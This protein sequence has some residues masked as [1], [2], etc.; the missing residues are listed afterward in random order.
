MDL[1][2]TILETL[3][4][5]LVCFQ[6]TAAVSVQVDDARTRRVIDCA[7]GSVVGDIVA[8]L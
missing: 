5:D 4:H 6:A 3:I 1:K 7:G 2:R 8:A